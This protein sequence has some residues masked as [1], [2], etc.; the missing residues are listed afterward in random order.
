MSRSE[1]FTA[2]KIHQVFV[3]EHGISP[4]KLADAGMAKLAVVLPKVAAGE[5]EAQTAVADAS[6]NGLRD[7]RE[8]YREQRESTVDRTFCPRCGCIPDEVLDPLRIEWEA[9]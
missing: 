8:E 7:L 3:L 5:I 1:F 2:A 4:D 6:E 9:V